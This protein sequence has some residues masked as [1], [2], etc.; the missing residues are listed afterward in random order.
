MK[1]F[2][3]SILFSAL[4]VG[5]AACQS[6]S[7][8]IDG[9]VEG[10]SDGDTLF[11]TQ[12]LQT[13]MPSDT[14]IV[15]DGKFSFSGT[16]DSTAL[17]MVYSALRNEI[18]APFF[19]EPGTVTVHLSEKPGASRVSGTLCNDKW[20]EL[21]DSVIVIGKEINRIAEHIYSNNIP[22]EEQEKGMQTIEKLNQRFAALILKTAEKNID[23]EFGYFLLTYYPEEYIDKA[24]RLRL[25]NKMDDDMRQRTAIRQMEQQLTNAAKTAEGATIKDFSMNDLDGNTISLLDEVKKHKLTIIDFWASWC[26][27]CRQEMPNLIKLYENYQEKGL[28]IIGVSLDSDR[29]AWTKSTSALGIKWPQMSDLKGWEN[30]MAVYFQVTSIPHTVVVDNSGKI[31]RCGLRG[32]Q[33]EEFVDEQLK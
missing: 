15:K 8:K 28:G 23:N 17:S 32:I 24:S 20:Q 26:A 19:M 10:L 7:F 6:N 30:E 5:L 2:Q 13:G 29:D 31:L 33:L 9:T 16:V 22:A 25:I 3:A 1:V 4:V 18:N 27:P 11:V 21:N 14:I 12:D